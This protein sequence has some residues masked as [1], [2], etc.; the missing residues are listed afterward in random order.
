MYRSIPSRYVPH[1]YALYYA[2]NTAG[3]VLCEAPLTPTWRAIVLQDLLL[4][5]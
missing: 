5:K 1:L 3:T 4:G 2:L